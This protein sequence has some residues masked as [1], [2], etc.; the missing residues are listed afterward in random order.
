[1][2]TLG[3]MS[4]PVSES[5]A[6]SGIR[7]PGI[8]TP[9]AL[10][11]PPPTPKTSPATQDE[12]PATHALP[13]LPTPHTP[14]CDSHPSPLEDRRA[15]SANSKSYPPTSATAHDANV[16]AHVPPA[17]AFAPT[18]GDSCRPLPPTPSGPHLLQTP[19]PPSRESHR[20]P[21]SSRA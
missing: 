16:G 13:G 12:A 19:L 5:A 17:I 14:A 2:A 8:N 3:R 20:H 7:P 4:R 10:A 21:R 15:A 6:C 18:S 11:T 1:M 9:P